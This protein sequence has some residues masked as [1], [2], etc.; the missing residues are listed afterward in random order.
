MSVKAPPGIT[1]QWVRS[2]LLGEPD[3]ENVE[4]RLNAGWAFVQPSAQPD[5]KVTD[6]A[7]AIEKG[8]LILMEKATHLV[9]E[10]LRA[11]HISAMKRMLG[12]IGVH[13]ADEVTAR[14]LS[15][16]S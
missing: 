15:Q 5:L 13:D 3:P 14:I 2:A 11:Q 1:Y 6:A 10:E 8:G 12:S 7:E 16:D 9:E 4:R